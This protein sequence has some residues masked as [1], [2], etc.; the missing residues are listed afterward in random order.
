MKISL[1]WL[2]RYLALER[3]PGEIEAA[4]TLLGFEVE[5][6]RRTGLAPLDKVVVGEILSSERHPNANRLRVCRVTTGDGERERTIV[7]GATNYAVGDRVAVALVGAALPSGIKIRKSKFR[8]I[9]SK[10]MMCSER[11]LNLGND[12]S[13]LLI[14]KS[15]PEIGTPIN[16]VFPGGDAIFDIEVTPNRPDCLSYLGI[17][18]ELAAYF[19]LSVKYP[20]IGAS[21]RDSGQGPSTLLLKRVRIETPENCPHYRAYSIAGVSVGPSPEWLQRDLTAIGLRPINNVVDITNFVL[22]ETGQ[23]LHAFDAAKIGGSS[24]IIRQAREGEEITTLDDKER[25]LDGQMAVIADREKPLVIG[26]VMGSIDAEVDESTR[27]IVLESANFNPS[28]IRRTSRVLAFSS[29]SSYRFER[30]VD[31]LGTERAALRAI[32]LITEVA[33]G[34]FLGMPHVGGGSQP[35]DRSFLIAPDFVRER[36]GFDVADGEIR[37]AFEGLHLQVSEEVAG[38]REPVWRVSIPSFRLDLE[39][40]IDLVEEFLRVYGTDRIP[41]TSVTV[42]GLVQR[43]DPVSKMKQIAG[44]YLVGHNFNECANYSMRA[45][46]ELRKWFPECDLGVLALSNP[47]GLDQSHLRPSLIPGLLDCVRLNRS[48]GN[49]PTRLFERG[50]VFREVDGSIWEFISLAFLV[51]EAEGQPTWRERAPADFFTVSSVAENLLRL[52]G[53]A[54]PEGAFRPI[55]SHSIWQEGH[56]AALGDARSGYRGQAGLLNAS[57]LRAWDVEG[58]VRAG[59]VWFLPSFLR[60]ER[61][62]RKFAAF[63]RYPAVTKDLAL[64]VDEGILAEEVRSKL[65]GVAGSAVERKFAVEKVSVFDLYRG[66]GLPEHSK[67]L[68]FSI[69]FR[70]LERTLTD[71]EVNEVFERIL[72]E[73]TEGTGYTLRS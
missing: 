41:P 70:S 27:D 15:R 22:F 24:L 17:A 65:E 71:V 3:T 21:W 36:I 60:G 34:R 25:R 28:N 51:V 68:A 16:E 58:P 14:L 11:E 45:S 10:G 1:E 56:S 35:V 55:G 61:S 59:E 37:K 29:D 18:R 5:S 33:G 26:G 42:P 47:L 48:R 52:A 6:V 64:V 66:E 12:Q 57:F 39:Q 38:R 46:D 20:E 32:D 62:P 44:D 40:P 31:P 13:G 49:Q 23:P 19:G 73:I 4:L 30:G 7:C 63:S 72:K 9:L 43:D 2:G 67:S 53:V 8:G 69:R 54:V 50:S